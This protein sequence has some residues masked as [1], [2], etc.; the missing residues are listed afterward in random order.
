MVDTNSV[1]APVRARRVRS[2]T[3]AAA[4]PQVEQPTPPPARADAHGALGPVSTERVR[5]PLGTLR[6]RLDN[7][8]I[9]GF[10]C[11]WFNDEKSRIKDALEA[12]YE[13]VKDA[14]GKPVSHI[15]GAKKEGGP[16]IAYRMKLPTEW[17]RQDQDAK[18]AVRRQRQKDMQRGVT[19]K[20]GP[21]DDG[22]YMPL[23]PDGRPLTNIK[24]EAR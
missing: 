2:E 17:W 11:H 18:V 22:R 9:P 23:G 3:V 4:A 8:P 15:V 21:G 12:G 7:T 20:G 5:K 16:L 10:H 13:H 14:D 6:E 19:G 24:N 1:P